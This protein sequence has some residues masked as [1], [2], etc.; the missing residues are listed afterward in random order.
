M[1]DRFRHAIDGGLRGIVEARRG[2]V[3][4]IELAYLRTGAH[5]SA[6]ELYR[7]SLEGLLRVEDEPARLINAAIGR[8]T[9]EGSTAGARAGQASAKRRGERRA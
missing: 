1:C 5:A 7:L 9:A 4:A 3:T 8:S 2:L 6:V